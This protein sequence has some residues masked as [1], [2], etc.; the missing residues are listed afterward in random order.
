MAWELFFRQNAGLGMF[1]LVLASSSLILS[2]IRYDLKPHLPFFTKSYGLYSSQ[3]RQFIL[4]LKKKK[5]VLGKNSLVL[6]KN[7][8][9]PFINMIGSA[10]EQKAVTC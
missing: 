9:I 10:K 3:I 4:P 8:S 6:F 5:K 7:G 1:V 2:S